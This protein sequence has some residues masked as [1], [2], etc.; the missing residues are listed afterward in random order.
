MNKL[1]EMMQCRDL[2]DKYRYPIEM[3][4]GITESID[5]II[6]EGMSKRRV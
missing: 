1:D 2:M 3:T 5:R 4:R 6:T